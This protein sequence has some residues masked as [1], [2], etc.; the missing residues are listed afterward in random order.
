MSPEPL[1]RS[2][3]NEADLPWWR[4]KSFV[5]RLLIIAVAVFLVG[6]LGYF[7]AL[8]AFQ[9]FRNARII[10]IA[11]SFLGT[12]DY[13]SAYLL[14]DQYLKN[15]PENLEARRLL[16]KVLE[17]Y[18]AGQG[19][20]EWESLVRLEPDNAANYI[21]YITSALRVRQLQKLPETLAILQK[22]QPDGLDYHR[23]SAGLALV[24]GD[25]V[26]LRKSI[27]AL[28]Q[29]EPDNPTTQFSLAT[30]RLNSPVTAEVA[31][32]RE[33]LEKFARGDA[34]RI[35]ATLALL[36][37]APKRWP[38]E[39]TPA[40]LYTQL[41]RQLE[42]G[43]SP[44]DSPSGFMKTG[45]VRLREPGLESLLEHLQTQ[46]APTSEDVARLAQWMLKIGR[47]RDALVWLETLPPPTRESP[48]ALASMA[49]CAVGLEAWDKLEQLLLQGAWGP[50]PSE[51]VKYAFQARLLR[52]Q[53]ND[54]RAETIWNNAIKAAEPSLPGMRLLHR[55]VQIWHWPGKE[56]PVLWALVRRFPND[57][58]AWQK[59]TEQ[60]LATR[61]TAQ[62]WRVY[63][64]WIQAMPSNLQPQI[65]RVVVGLLVRPQ[66]PG[67]AN[68]ASELFRLHPNNPGCRLAQAL[69]LWRG[70]LSGE[71]LIVLDAVQ[72]NPAAEPRVALTRGL[73]LSALGRRT[74]S[75]RMFGLLQTE[76]LLPEEGALIAAARNGTK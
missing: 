53:K 50:V 26:A 17:E 12:E 16:A 45:A 4:A 7:V 42:I 70:G 66:E 43:K 75:E 28:A 6:A 20:T 19:L 65:E 71:A 46:P 39:K 30:L 3:E 63:N 38:K 18:G 10:R 23:L 37:D 51:A 69:A 61:E 15:H 21:G 59:L 22:L 68:R 32:A 44:L 34:L 52:E 60:V 49:A 2:A 11:N 27:E 64:A 36:D 57:N 25:A 9:N 40:K 29:A 67:L 73:V 24:N 48:A 74:E 58:Q 72:L 76:A 1:N 56:V 47:A 33:T 54:S 8:P 35:R 62:V 14:L 55:L 5:K 41:A 13:R 31:A